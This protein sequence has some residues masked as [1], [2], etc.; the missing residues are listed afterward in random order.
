MRSVFF[1]RVIADKFDFAFLL[2]PFERSL[3]IGI[4]DDTAG[5]HAR[6]LDSAVLRYTR[7]RRYVRRYGAARANQKNRA[8]AA[9]CR[10]FGLVSGQYKIVREVRYASDFRI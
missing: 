8:A 2:E 4:L 5:I 6:K 3:G 10:S 9:L 7:S 1:D